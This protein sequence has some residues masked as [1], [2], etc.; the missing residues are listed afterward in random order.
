MLPTGMVNRGVAMRIPW[1]LTLALVAATIPAGA[2]Q[3]NNKLAVK[4]SHEDKAKS[5]G[6][7]KAPR[8]SNSVEL[9]KLEQQTAKAAAGPKS[10]GGQHVSRVKTQRDKAN[11]PIHFTSGTGGHG[12]GS[13]SPNSSKSR[14]RTKGKR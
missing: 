7:I 6:A 5:G 3:K 4:A 11:P 9:Q 10:S 14:V 2:Q 13:G 8:N 1:I 12:S